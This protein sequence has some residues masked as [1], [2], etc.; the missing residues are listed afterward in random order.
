[1]ESVPGRT[2]DALIPKSGMPVRELLR[3]AERP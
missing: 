1:M 3:V 2:L